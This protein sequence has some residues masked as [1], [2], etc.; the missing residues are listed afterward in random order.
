MSQW[1]IINRMSM[2]FAFVITQPGIPLIYYG[3]EIGLAGWA[4][5]DNRRM[6]SFEPG[7][8]DNQRT[9]LARIQALGSARRDHEALRRGRFQELW[10]DDDLFI[11]ARDNGRGDVAIVAMNKGA[12]RIQQVPIPAELGLEGVSMTDTLA[13]ERTVVVGGGQVTFTLD[14]WEYAIFIQ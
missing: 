11:Y 3:D 12:D 13:G 8:S 2:G 10:V 7:L 9:L 1:E 14:N 5:P 6:M 4:D